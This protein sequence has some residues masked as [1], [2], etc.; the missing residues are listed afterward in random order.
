MS[1][2]QQKENLNENYNICIKLWTATFEPEL[3]TD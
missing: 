2:G 3:R 1:S